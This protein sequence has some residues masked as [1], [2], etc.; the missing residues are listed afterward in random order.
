VNIE[1]TPGPRLRP[2]LQQQWEWDA[3]SHIQFLIELESTKYYI[4][5]IFNR[6]PMSNPIWFDFD[7]DRAYDS[8]LEAQAR[9]EDMFYELLGWMAE[10]VEEGCESL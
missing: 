5:V 4:S 8:L 1:W 7:N 9:A 6:T 2:H 3:T 10:V